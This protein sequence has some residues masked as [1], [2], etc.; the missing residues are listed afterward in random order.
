MIQIDDAGWGCLLGGVL[1]GAYREQTQEFACVEAPV[2]Q[3]QGAAFIEK[4]YLAGAVDAARDVLAQLNVEKDEPIRICTGYVLDGIR[5]MLEAE[6]YQWQTAKIVGPLQER[7]EGALLERLHAL[8]VRDLDYETLTGKQGLAFYKCLRWLKG[9]NINACQP[10]PGREQFAK[11]GWATYRAWAYLP[12][13]QAK[14]EA[15][16]VKNRQRAER[17]F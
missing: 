14:A 6:G 10:A 13:A 17:L 7:I 5:G 11:T 12:Y 1:I 3:F 15:K 8:G 2:N 16:R 9:E 4:A